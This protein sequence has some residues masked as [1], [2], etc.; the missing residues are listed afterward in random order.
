MYFMIII[1]IC[2]FK[3]GKFLVIGEVFF[4]VAYYT[5]AL[6]VFTD[7]MGGLLLILLGVNSIKFLDMAGT[8]KGIK[9]LE[10]LVH[11]THFKIRRW[12]INLW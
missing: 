6:H 12:L 10:I 9:S 1:R 4:M 5:G 3:N 8:T 2:S 7:V 11:S